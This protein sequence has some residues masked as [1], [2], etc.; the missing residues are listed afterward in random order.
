MITF[1]GDISLDEGMG[2]N[3][4]SLKEDFLGTYYFFGNLERPIIDKETKVLPMPKAGPSLRSDLGSI[5][6]IKTLSNNWFLNLANNHLMDY[7]ICGLENTVNILD[8]LS[9]NYGGIGAKKSQAR[10]IV[11]IEIEH[12]RIGVFCLNENQFGN[13][14]KNTSG[15]AGFD[16]G[17]FYDLHNIRQKYDFII[18][19]FHA[20]AEMIPIPSPWIRNL[21]KTFIDLGVDVIWGH[22]AHV[23][24]PVEIYHG[25]PIIYSG[26][27]FLVNP[28]GWK[29]KLHSKSLIASINPLNPSEVRLQWTECFQN[30]RTGLVEVK[31]SEEPE[32]W[33]LIEKIM[34]MPDLYEG[35]WQE[36]SFFLFEKVF[37][38]YFLKSFSRSRKHVLLNSSALNIKND[39]LY[40][41]F[42][43]ESH[44]EVLK[45]YFGVC[46]GSILDRRTDESQQ[47]FNQIVN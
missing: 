40:H 21:Y 12:L 28:R 4:S 30:H 39:V 41:L 5:L 22:H 20:A 32:F 43:C 29:E 45:T 33:P 9:F 46:S 34:F 2:A 3:L 11:E 26:G 13:A 27:N 31:L 38:N 19:S 15:V 37:Q 25:K 47:I 16:E 24:Q 10:S 23:P 1:V 35:V 14:D 8:K 6:S 42:A 36:A 18:L 17:I 44:R 7:G